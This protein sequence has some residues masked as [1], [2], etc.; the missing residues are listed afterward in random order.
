MIRGT[1]G[2]IAPN[3]DL[4]VKHLCRTCNVP[5]AHPAR[6]QQLIK[7]NIARVLIGAWRSVVPLSA[8][9]INGVHTISTQV[10]AGPAVANV[11]GCYQRLHQVN[12]EGTVLSLPAAEGIGVTSLHY[13]E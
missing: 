6:D 4:V 7:Q 3:A 9:L 8:R 13:V 1:A 5:I 2:T 12:K 11:I 10:A